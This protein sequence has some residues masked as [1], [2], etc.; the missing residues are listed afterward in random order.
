MR[1]LA[2][3]S[4]ASFSGKLTR[5]HIMSLGGSVSQPLGLS[6]LCILSIS[7]GASAG[8]SNSSLNMLTTV[9]FISC[10]STDSGI[11][12]ILSGSSLGYQGL[13]G[14]YGFQEYVNGSNLTIVALA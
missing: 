1:S 3:L 2:F 7:M 6:V 8:L 14:V 10:C 4:M 13:P 12:L 9:Y 5:Q 11:L